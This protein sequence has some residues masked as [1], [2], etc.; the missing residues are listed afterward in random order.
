MQLV[1]LLWIG[2]LTFPQAFALD[3]C[4]GQKFGYKAV[5][6]ADPHAYYLCF[7]LLGKIRNNCAEGFRFNV[8]SQNCAQVPQSSI[9]LKNA[10]SGVR[11]EFNINQNITMD[12]PI[13]FNI[14][15]G[16]WNKPPIPPFFPPKPTFRPPTPPTIDVSS[17]ES[18]SSSSETLSTESTSS[19]SVASSTE[20]SSSSSEAS[21]TASSSSSSEASSTESSSSSSEASS[22][23]SS[24]S[25]SEASSTASSSS[26]SEASST[27]SSSSSSEASSTESSSSSSE[28]SSTDSSSSSSEASSTESSSS[29]SE[30]STTE[31]SS[32]SSEASSTESSS[33]SSEASSTESS[34]SSSEASTTESSSSSSEAS[35]T[36]SSSS[37]SEA[38]STESSSSSSEASSTDSS[39][40]SS[41]ASSTESS[42]SSSEASSTESSSSSSEASSTESS[43]SSSEA[44]ST[45]SSSSSS[46]ASSTESSSSSSEASSTE[47]SSSS[48]EDS[49][50][51]SSSSSSEASSTESSSSSSEASSTESSSSSSEASSTES[52]SSSSE[53]SSTESSSSSSESSSTESSSSSSEA[54]STDNTE[55]TTESSTSNS[56]NSTTDTTDSTSEDS[57]QSSSSRSDN[58]FTDS[59]SSSSEAISTDS[60]ISSSPES[61]TSEDA[62]PSES[63]VDSLITSSEE[64]STS[65]E[66]DPAESSTEALPTSSEGTET[67]DTSSED[68]LSTSENPFDE[69]T[70]SEDINSSTSE[71]PLLSKPIR[72]DVGKL[73]KKL[74]NILWIP[75][76]VEA[77]DSVSEFDKSAP[78][79]LLP[80]GAYLRDPTSCANFY[81]CA[82]GRAIL[83]KCP[84]NLYFDIESKVCNLPNLVDCSQ[85]QESISIPKLLTYSFGNTV[86]SSIG[87]TQSDED[88]IEDSYLADNELSTSFDSSALTTEDLDDDLEEDSETS[89]S[90]TLEYT[91][92]DIFDFDV[93]DTNDWEDT[94][95]FDEESICSSQPNGVHLRHPN[96]CSKFYICASGRAVLR[97]CPSSLY[98]D[99]KKRVCNFPAAV[100]C[101]INEDESVNDGNPSLLTDKQPK[102][103]SNTLRRAKSPKTHK[104]DSVTS[105]S[106]SLQGSATKMEQTKLSAPEIL[107]TNNA[108]LSSAKSDISSS[109]NANSPKEQGNLNNDLIHK[110]SVSSTNKVIS[111]DTSDVKQSLSKLSVSESIKSKDTP[112]PSPG[113][114]LP[115]DQNKFDNDLTPKTAVSSSTKTVIA[116]DTSDVTQVQS[117]L[118]VSES[119]KSKETSL[120]SPI[121]LSKD[122]G[123]PYVAQ[124]LKAD[125]PKEQGKQDKDLISKAAVLLST[126]T[127]IAKDTS[128]VTQVQS[129]LS[130]SE[131]LKSKETSLPSPII[132]SKDQG[133]PYVAQNLKADLPKEQGKQDKDLISK[134]AVSS[135]TKTVISKD[136]SEVKQVQSKLST[137]ENIKSKETPLP[138]PIFNQSKNQGKLYVAQNLKGDL[139]KDQSKPNK[140]LISKAAVSS[141]TKTV[142]S[143]ETSEVNQVQ[144]KLSVSE[145]IK[146]KEMPLPL[147]VT[148]SKDQGKPY[149]AQ[150]L[151]GDLSKDQSKP[152]KDLISK[153]AVSSS[154]KT[155]ISKDTSEVNQVQ[156]KLSVSEDIKSKEMPLPLP[157]TL[158]KDQGKPYVAQ[159]LKT[160]LLKDQG[161]LN[162]DLISKAA[163]SSSTKTVI[164]KETSEVKQV[165]NK[166]STSENIKS[167]ETPLPS[168]ILNQ[169]KNQG[170]PYVAQNLKTDQSKD[171]SKPN[172]DLISKA[173]VSSSTKTIIS[174]DT[175]EVKQVQSKLS[176][177]ENIKSKEMPMP[178]PVMLSK[179]QGKPY[180]AQNL[181]TVLSKDQG[182][183]NKALIS[184]ATVASSTKIIASDTPEVKNE[185]SK[186]SLSESLKSKETPLPSP[187]T[188]LSKDQNKL[189]KDLT[190]K[191]TSSSTKTVIA[192]DTS[193]VKQ[194]QSKLSVSES[195][196]S[197]ETPLP[198][199]ILIQSKDQGKPNIAQS[200]KADLSK[201][202][203]KL[204]KALI[205]KAAVVSSTKIIAKDTSE[206][207]QAQSKLTDSLKSKET[208]P[209]SLKT[210]LSKIQD[211]PEK[212][213]S[214]NA[215]LP[216][217]NSDI[218]KNN[219][220]GVI[221][222]ISES[223]QGQNQLLGP[224]ESK[225]QM[226]T[227]VVE[228][229]NS[230]EMELPLMKSVL[231]KDVS[232]SKEELSKVGSAKS[233]ETVLLATKTVTSNKNSIP[234]QGKEP[235]PKSDL[236]DSK[237]AVK[238]DPTKP[239]LAE[240]LKSSDAVLSNER[241]SQNLEQR[242]LPVSENL[243]SKQTYSPS[244]KSDLS[245]EQIKPG[246]IVGVKS[247][248]TVIPSEKSNLFKN[249]PK[250]ED[251][252]F[253]P[254]VVEN[255]K[256]KEKQL[257]STKSDPPKKQGQ[258]KPSV[259]ENPKAQEMSLAQSKADL[260]KTTLKAEQNK[261]KPTAGLK[262]KETVVPATIVD[263][264]KEASQLKMVQTQPAVGSNLKSNGKVLYSTKTDHSKEHD[265]PSAAEA[266]KYIEHLISS[267]QFD[268][269]KNASAL[270]NLQIVSKAENIIVPLE[271]A[272]DS[273][274]SSLPNGA[275]IRDPNLCAKF[276]VCSNGRA[277]P[278]SCPNVLFFDIKKK[279]CNFPSLVDC[280]SSEEDYSTAPQSPLSLT[281]DSPSEPDDSPAP[282]CSLFP[283]GEYVRHPRSCS[284]FYV[285][286]NGKAI[287]RQCPKGLYI[288]TEIK[289]CNYPSR[290]RCTIEV[291][292]S[293]SISVITGTEVN[294][295]NK[296]D[297]TTM[298]DSELHNKYYVC[299]NGTPV[300]HFCDPG[301][302]FDL[303]RGVCDQKQLVDHDPLVPWL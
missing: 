211:S 12:R 5:D 191:T 175:S 118:S 136:T 247:N 50:T 276:Y 233:S 221:Q 156:S 69:T 294:C 22:T 120:P 83:R 55:D 117:K 29:S 224:K 27:E 203:S 94:T 155:I 107:K 164:S 63:S 152:N 20:S 121:I 227:S 7:G 202:Q 289:Y 189:D 183:L 205:S 8:K 92:E 280:T 127:V 295:I 80:S 25:S 163:V 238:H 16:L 97:S 38:S 49:S 282:D 31:S 134:A 87:T 11:N 106:S 296:R 225:D 139:S 110:G 17:T 57:T 184:K 207:K 248:K 186:L 170:K 231:T 13:I 33:S 79:A 51:E 114:Y 113:T 135:S 215:I 228:S 130:V 82:N 62:D 32:S 192:K 218:S 214:N 169:S 4:A 274:C 277:I 102:Y 287:P 104:I 232:K 266:L 122:Q 234:Q 210:D 199:S 19:S 279:V 48:S 240:S 67:E 278:H 40:S 46:E 220:S 30:A 74:D 159:N 209:A 291:A 138:S 272:I 264:S 297:G 2:L 132:L 34:S 44:S 250:P 61:S 301:K 283:N 6:P 119:L 133:K 168:P 226:S 84:R 71:T 59:S 123:K 45:E 241:S 185:Q 160:D 176:V 28:A 146:S 188:Y 219:T 261:T 229:L 60:S 217:P 298:R 259:V 116:K 161:K 93:F 91:E 112:L 302:W 111:K 108:A 36:E 268:L 181:K 23:E 293:P 254:T 86:G 3:A 288:D 204:N 257:S 72:A 153:A 179:D 198:S 171:Q 47:S 180:V 262:S 300:T 149:V 52:S 174:K 103:L 271:D 131:S 243:K 213:E 78:C 77:A 126:K 246:K 157:V 173:A 73:G 101:S 140:D 193:Q 270:K 196:K 237:S 85:Q 265:I 166:L 267:T 99:I 98:F 235:M 177:S 18:S 195:L 39:S 290:V 206:V 242:K 286:A 90:P 96:S 223:K 115:K 53:D 76:E 285:C 275:F 9:Q 24:S 253:K 150:N 81:V 258:S 144:S 26:S 256:H 66:T 172:K 167:K 251:K 252:H 10:G 230:N 281:D 165:Q 75:T 89:E 105:G 182:K 148:L 58:S 68:P 41:E 200:L 299:R 43:S 14:F 239:S 222:K 100:D 263:L 158:S 236:T 178:S 128:D 303:N 35:S 109:Q 95:Y 260:S 190:S 54:S 70:E 197:K 244:T 21:S 42:S 141:S 142:I 154:T 65:E 125:L 249:T 216:P 56:E 273:K 64:S 208:V 212:I 187:G 292:P 147:P 255:L 37:S 124:N 137:S 151:K 129:K 201:D 162:K 245:K 143:K 269:S 1:N 145:D 284:K 15:G 88:V 194:E